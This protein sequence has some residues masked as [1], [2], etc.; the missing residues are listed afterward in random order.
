MSRK[1]VVITGIGVISPLGIGISDTFDALVE[2]K[3]GI[4]RIKSFDPSFFPSQIAGEI[5]VAEVKDCVPKGYRKAT[6]VMARDIELAVIAAYHAVKDA[7]LQTKCIV[8]RGEADKLN[9][10]STRFGANIG[11]G[12]ICADLNELA[13]ALASAVEDSSRSTS[14][15]FTLRKWGS[16]GMQN[17][18][19]LWLLKFLPNML[20][21]HVTIVHDCQAPSNT[22]TC[23][24]ASSHLAVGEAYRTIERGAADIC[25]CGGA[26]S[27]LNPMGLARQ[28]L[29]Q[30]LVTNSNENPRAACRPFD[31]DRSGSVISEGGGLLILEEIER[32]KAR[33]AR[34]YAEVVGFGASTN[35]ASWNKP[36]ADGRGL[37]IAMKKAMA[38]AGVTADQVDLI[39]AS[40]V[41]TREHDQ[42]EAAAI[43]S[44]FGERAAKVPVLA[45]K[46]AIGNNGAGAGA[47]DLAVTATAFHRGVIPPS[48]NTDNVDPECGLNVVRGDPADCRS[49]VAVSMASSLSGGQTAAL[50][51]RRWQS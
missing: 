46:G 28:Q 24:E 3:C 13:G 12:L 26:E 39:N 43:R 7:G 1:R 22:I 6:K 37:S 19:P 45:A 49:S 35:A 33:G 14:R 16:E 11:A 23:G 25:I 29:L 17:L 42:S 38:D 32:A 31:R 27:K 44:V 2:K 21:C 4:D 5:A 9:V 40:G 34:I 10:D 20:A 51:L 36:Q 48:L 15:E 18:T 8:D 50:V 41:G 30:R 47:I